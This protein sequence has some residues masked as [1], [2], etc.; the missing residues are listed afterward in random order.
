LSAGVALAVNAL[1]TD[2]LPLVGDLVRRRS[3]YEATGD[4]STFL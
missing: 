3:Y 4:A 1:R 2:R